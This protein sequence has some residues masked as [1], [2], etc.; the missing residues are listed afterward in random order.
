MS[1]TNYGT[2]AI[3]ALMERGNIFQ[4]LAG[5]CLLWAWAFREEWRKR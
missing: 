1:R 2:E 5:A 3:D 4:V